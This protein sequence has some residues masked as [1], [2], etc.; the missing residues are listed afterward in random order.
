MHCDFSAINADGESDLSSEF[1]TLCKK[2]ANGLIKVSEQLDNNLLIYASAIKPG[3]RFT[4]E[5]SVIQI[6]AQHG[7]RLI[8]SEQ[9][10]A[11]FGDES[12]V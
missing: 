4:D 1:E 5:Q 9:V 12:K 10:E 3:S 2:Q 11:I 7:V 8:G 6:T